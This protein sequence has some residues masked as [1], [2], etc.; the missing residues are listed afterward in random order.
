M[1]A[2]RIL[3]SVRILD[4]LRKSRECAV[5]QS[6]SLASLGLPRY[7]HCQPSVLPV[8]VNLAPDQRNWIVVRGNTETC[9]G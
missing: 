2:V 4:V 5:L 6:F 9:R 7:E 3:C 8:P 1:N